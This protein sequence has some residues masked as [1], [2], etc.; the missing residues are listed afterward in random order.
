MTLQ[1]ALYFSNGYIF[2]RYYLV[3]SFYNINNIIINISSS[4]SRSMY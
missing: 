4:S 2:S 3:Y 1:F